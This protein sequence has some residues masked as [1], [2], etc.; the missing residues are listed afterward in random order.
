MS[1]TQMSMYDI[2]AVQMWWKNFQLVMSFFLGLLFLRDSCWPRNYAKAPRV[3]F[4]KI[5]LL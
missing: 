5:G 1:C 2:V 4:L 3:C